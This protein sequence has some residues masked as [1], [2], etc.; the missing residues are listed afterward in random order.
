MPDLTLLFGIGATKSGTSWLH[1]WLS[2]HPEVHLWRH[3]E[4]H[5]FDSFDLGTR[6][7]Q[8]EV[9]RQRRDRMAQ[10]RDAAAR[11]VRRQ[12][13]DHK[14]GEFDRYLQLLQAEGP[15][16]AAYM[17]FLTEGRDGRRVVGDVTPAYSLLGEERL[18]FMAALNPVTRFVYLMRDPVERLW[19]NVRATA[20][21]RGGDAAMVARRAAQ[22]FDRWVRGEELG[23]AARCD[24]AGALRRLFAAVPERDRFVGFYE[25][26]FSAETTTRL[27]AFLGIGAQPAPV[28]RAVN[29]GPAVPLDA[30]RRAVAAELLAP[31]YHAVKSLIG[32]VPGR[33]QP[34]GVEV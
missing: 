5:Y 10:R 25:E 16:G 12:W 4:V 11:P 3:K 6:A 29:Q 7:R 22:V 32:R 20:A 24:Y 19:S 13:L 18:R 23:I 14:I 30:A 8:I 9:A 33:W 31:Q 1:A 2:G 21:I 34:M 27:C 28:D 17:Q 15:D 26:L